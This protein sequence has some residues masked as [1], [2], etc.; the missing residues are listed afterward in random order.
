MLAWKAIH[1]NDRLDVPR[2][3]IE[4]HF[5]ILLLKKF[6]LIFF[7]YKSYKNGGGVDAMEL[8]VNAGMES[9]T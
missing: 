9:D 5:H 3:L 1:K 8:P 4:K 7:H 2:N 6:F